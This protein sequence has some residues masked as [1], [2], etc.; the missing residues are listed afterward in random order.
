MMEIKNERSLWHFVLVISVKRVW[1]SLRCEI[2]ERNPFRIV[3]V[4]TFA[5]G[6]SHLMDFNIQ[7]DVS[8]MNLIICQTHNLSK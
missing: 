2:G 8:A 3:Y 5:S 7:S 1:E 4:T 6:R